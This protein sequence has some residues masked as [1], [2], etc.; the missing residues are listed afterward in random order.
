MDTFP[1]SRSS[2]LRLLALLLL[3]L[4]CASRPALATEAVPLALK[5]YDTVA[6]FTLHD[7]VA[8]KPEFEY[9]W[10]E[11]RYRFASA[12]HMAL[13][14]ADPAHYAPRFGNICTSA[15]AYGLPWEADP[16]VWKIYEGRLYVFGSTGSRDTFVKDPKRVISAAGR[17]AER[18]RKGLR[19]VA[20]IPL[21][22]DLQAGFT[23]AVAG[24][25]R[26]PHDPR[27]NE[28]QLAEIRQV[29]DT[30]PSV[31]DPGP[32]RQDPARP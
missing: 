17:N 26:D 32:P 18:L 16:T 14:K 15:L 24:C 19:P 4:S 6:Y 3:A 7:A 8:G 23:Q 21:P 9:E 2:L 11:R 12:A 1:S 31:R 30:Q 22:A 5:G 13:F 27:C 28:Q 10:D 20:E 29:L 25:K